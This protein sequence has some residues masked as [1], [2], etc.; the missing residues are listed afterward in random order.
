MENN[1]VEIIYGLCD[2]TGTCDSYFGFFKKINDAK[3]EL[4]T[5]ASRLKEDLGM[6]EIEI[7]DNKAI[8][9]TNEKEKTVIQIQKFMLK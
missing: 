9:I 6:M 8:I 5:Q 7:K 2:K 3:K 1:K 4:Q